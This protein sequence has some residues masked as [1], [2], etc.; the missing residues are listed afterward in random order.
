MKS[1]IEPLVVEIQGRRTEILDKF[2]T[3]TST[4]GKPYYFDLSIYLAAIKMQICCD[5]IENAIWMIDHPP[6]FYRQNPIKELQDLKKLLYR[7]CYDIFDYADDEDEASWDKDAAAEQWSTNYCYPR[8]AII[9]D[10]ITALNEKGIEPWIFDLSCSHGNLPLGLM[11]LP[12]KFKYFGKSMNTRAV[13]KLKEWCG[14]YWQDKP[15]EGQRTTLVCT[16][17]LEHAWRT[18]DIVQAAWK[19]GIE[20]DDIFLSTPF[21]TLFQGLPNYESRRLGHIR[22]IT[23]DEFREFAIKG[24]PGYEWKHFSSYSQV[25]YGKKK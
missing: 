21:G 14:D 7:N 15:K 9:T 11:R 17:A 19:M 25:L 13:T 20:Y 8:A 16:E 24:F 4:F 18:D 12:V 1:N 3:D 22:G 5:E 23:E 10:Y 6:A 2:N